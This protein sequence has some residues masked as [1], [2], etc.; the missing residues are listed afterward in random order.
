[1]ANGP[2]GESIRRRE[3]A[4]AVWEPN[5]P[6]LSRRYF[7]SERRSQRLVR[8]IQGLDSDLAQQRGIST[9]RGAWGSGGR[10]EKLCGNHFTIRTG[11]GSRPLSVRLR[12]SSIANDTRY[13]VCG[14]D[15]SGRIEGEDA[16]PFRNRSKTRRVHSIQT[17]SRIMPARTATRSSTQKS[18]CVG[19]RPVTVSTWATVA[20][21]LTTFGTKTCC[22]LN[23]RF[24]SSRLRMVA[25]LE[26]LVADRHTCNGEH[27][28]VLDA[29][30]AC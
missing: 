4:V 17:F 11:H 25:L 16:H 14:M 3:M 10:T 15:H 12:A 24:A 19:A 5:M 26:R 18:D 21:L 8:R 1:M 30:L 6:P 28:E 27:R 9:R 29:R 7:C 22:A 20:L 23:T 13:R 2:G